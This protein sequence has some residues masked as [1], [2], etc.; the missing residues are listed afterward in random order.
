LTTFVRD[1]VADPEA[2]FADSVAATLWTGDLRALPATVAFVDAMDMRE[3]LRFW[4]E[5]VANASNFTAVI[6][7]DF[8]IWQVSPL[9]ERYLASLP[10]GHAERPRDLGI[11]QLRGRM[12]RVIERGID[13]RAQTRITLGDTITWT[14]KTDSELNTLRD[15]VA[16][17]LQSR[18]REELGGTYDVSVTVNMRSGPPAEFEL[19]VGFTAAPERID[20]L[21][22]AALAELERLRTK[23]PT[24]DEAAKVRAAAVRHHDDDRDGN[25]YWASE[26]VAHSLL[27]WSLDSIADHGDAASEISVASLSAAAARYLDSRQYVRVTRM[28]TNRA[29]SR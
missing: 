26:L 14:M 12:E 28:P 19:T 27:G 7:G 15:L 3:G 11:P 23:G 6:V 5:R 17:V 22:G 16:L 29:G 13:P 24:K 4:K 10:P 9:I 25:Y 1:R 8:E 21:A 20:T 2:V 18:L